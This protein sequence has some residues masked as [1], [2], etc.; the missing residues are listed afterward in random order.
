M[1]AVHGRRGW[2]GAARATCGAG[3]G[4]GR[5]PWRSP[6]AAVDMWPP[7]DGTYLPPLTTAV[8][9]STHD[10]IGALMSRGDA[11]RAGAGVAAGAPPAGQVTNRRDWHRLIIT[12]ALSTRRRRRR[13]L[14]DD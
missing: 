1:A 14:G 6:R 9:P 2:G 11:V 13:R 8:P 12:Q 3:A 7:L 5:L 10:S 4:A